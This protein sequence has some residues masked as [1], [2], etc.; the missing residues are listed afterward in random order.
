MKKPVGTDGLYEIDID[1]YHSQACCV[2]PS[3]SSSGLRAILRECPAIFY[4]TSDLNPN[5]FEDVPSTPFAFGRAAHALVLGEPEF[6]K[7]FIVSPYDDFRS[8][9]AQAWRDQQEICGLQVLK[10]ADFKIVEAMAAAQKSSPEVARAFSDGS[11]ELSL[12]WKDDETGIWLKARP[13]WLPTLPDFRFTCEYKTCVSIHHVKLSYDVF[14]YGYEMQAAMALD[15]IAAVLK[16]R[17]FGIAHVVQEKTPPYL[18]ELRCFNADQIQWGRRQYR[19]A[20]RIFA[21]C[22]ERNEW[23]GYTTIP[24]VFHTPF[25]V[26]KEMESFSDDGNSNTDLCAT[27]GGYFESQRWENDPA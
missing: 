1:V 24:W 23:P 19:K 17:P 18:A 11:P 10:A 7:K 21:H 25:S 13:D 2:G 6:N 5:R 9:V 16:I 20:L 3:V 27:G 14:K 22:L 15:G 12:I 4:A 8:K 26:Q